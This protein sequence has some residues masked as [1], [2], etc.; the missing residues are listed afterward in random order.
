MTAEPAPVASLKDKIKG[1][2]MPERVIEICLHTDLREQWEAADLEL[3][4]SMAAAAMDKRLN[5]GG[6]NRELAQ[7]V[8]AL[9]EAMQE[10]VIAFTLRALT[11][12]AWDELNRA[13]PPRDDNAEDAAVGVNIET[14]FDA[15]IKA[16]TISPELDDEDWALLLDDRLTA[17]QYAELQNAMMALNTRRASVP[18]SLA[19]SRILRP[20]ETE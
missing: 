15:A 9:Q 4:E 13:H 7:R 1:A 18:N 11:K 5:T 16:C 10:H 2:V 3:R 20:S 8:E 6:K 17:G 14:F 12:R 19:A